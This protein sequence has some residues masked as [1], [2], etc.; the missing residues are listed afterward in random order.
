[1][2]EHSADFEM[3]KEKYDNYMITEATLRRYVLIYERSGGERGITAE[4][5]EEITGQEY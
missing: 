4:E 5:F 2:A 1:M 3:L